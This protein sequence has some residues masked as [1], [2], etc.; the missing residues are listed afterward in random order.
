MRAT[1]AKIDLIDPFGS[2]IAFGRLILRPAEIREAVGRT[3]GVGFETEMVM[4]V[5]DWGDQRAPY[6]VRV[7]IE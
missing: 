4:P 5:S 7:T 1:Y 6:R 2:V 3:I